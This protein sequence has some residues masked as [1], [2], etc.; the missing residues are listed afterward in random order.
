M[1]VLYFSRDYTPHDYRFLSALNRTDHEIYYLRLEAGPFARENRPLPEGVRQVEWQGGKGVVNWADFT[2]LRGEL[3]RLLNEIKP[4]LVHAGPVQRCAL[5]TALTGFQPLVTMSWGSDLLKDAKAGLGRWAARFTLARTTVFICD[6]QPV[7]DV[8]ANLGMN[9]ERTVI[10]P[11]GVDLDHFFPGRENYIRS[12]LEW[13]DALIL[14]SSR[15]L[16]SVYGVDLL[17]DAFIKAAKE[18]LDLNMLMIGDG[19]LRNKIEQIIH[20]ASIEDRVHIGGQINYDAL[21]AYYRTADIYVSASHSDGSSISLL[22]AMACGLPAIV[23]D[24]PGNREWVTPNTNGWWFRDSDESALTQAMLEAVNFRE[25]LNAY[26]RKAREIAEERADW[27]VNFQH[28][29]RA[30]DLAMHLHGKRS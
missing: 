21:P 5:L 20:Q 14:L 22:E 3:K 28:L 13:D 4:D 27:E 1:K 30:Y 26:S 23:S 29:L 2:W 24:I 9:R 15:S 8:A 10:F 17:V 16:E 7:A 6:C 11:W 12:R 19:S 25:T 18:S